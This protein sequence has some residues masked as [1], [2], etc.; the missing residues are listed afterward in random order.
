MSHKAANQIQRPNVWYMY[1]NIFE[2]RNGFLVWLHTD[3]KRSTVV[4][5]TRM[6]YFGIWISPNEGSVKIWMV[7]RNG[8][9]SSVTT[10]RCVVLK[11]N[12]TI[13]T[14]G[15]IDFQIVGNLKWWGDV[16]NYIL[17]EPTWLNSQNRKNDCSFYRF[18]GPACQLN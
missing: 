6:N 5:R 11:Y 2:V 14:K 7:Y 1:C 4:A 10:T 16:L 9:T 8:C 17:L 13:V 18:M 3:E 15:L 12:V